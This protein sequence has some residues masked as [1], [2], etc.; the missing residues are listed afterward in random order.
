MAW[1]LPGNVVVSA[2]LDPTFGWAVGGIAA[3][4]SHSDAAYRERRATVAVAA[5]LLFVYVAAAAVAVTAD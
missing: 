1:L 4:R 5:N 2:A 3:S